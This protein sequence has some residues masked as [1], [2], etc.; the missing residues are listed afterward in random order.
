MEE[1]EIGWVVE[2]LRRSKTWAAKPR[3]RS[4]KR[5]ENRERVGQ[6]EWC[7]F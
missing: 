4:E 2:V 6:S 1:M 5:N 3:L 7:E